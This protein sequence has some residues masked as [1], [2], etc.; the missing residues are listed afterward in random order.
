MSDVLELANRLRQLNDDDLAG[1]LRER[2]ISPNHLRD[3]FDLAET[4]LQ[5]KNAE[6]WLSSLNLDEIRAIT[7]KHNNTNSP[8][9]EIASLVF[10]A[11]A[12]QKYDFVAR[13]E[14]V[15]AELGLQNP[16]LIET[17]SQSPSALG[18]NEKSMHST[19]SSLDQ[20]AIAVFE[21]CQAL[22]EIIYDLE[23]HRVKAVGKSGVASLEIKRLAAHLG[24]PAEQVKR[25]FEI[26]HF[27]DLVGLDS[28][29]WALTL[30]SLRWIG[31]STVERWQ[32]LSSSW[33][34]MV[35]SNG[36]ALF[37]SHWADLESSTVSRFLT[38]VYPFGAKDEDSR[39]QRLIRF[40]EALGL[41]QEDRATELFAL[42]IRQEFSVAQKL[43][44]S[45]LPKTQDRI[46]VQA[47]LSIVTP[48]PLSS[49]DERA[50]RAFVET[51]QIGIASRFRLTALSL[52]TAFEG[53]VTE[54]EIRGTLAR[55]SHGQLPQPVEYLIN[56]TKKRFGRIRVL[57]D[58]PLGGTRIEC[59]EEILAS[60]ILH[61]SALRPFA[62]GAIDSRTLKTKY[63]PEV[64]YFGLR[65]IGFLAIRVDECGQ[66]IAP[67]KTA[68]L[69]QENG[70]DSIQGTIERLR[71]ADAKV[72]ESGDDESML[73]QI[74]L[75]IK[76][77]A[78]VQVSYRGQDGTEYHFT[79]E[80]IGLAN[81]RLRGKDRKADI[82]RTL[83]LSNITKLSLV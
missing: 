64:V 10:S 26:A 9:A 77:R 39:S 3:F 4:M 2:A 41:V 43:L 67:I 83:T 33:S 37:K 75:A 58:R 71:N 53:G 65:E 18:S 61:N 13:F 12:N 11:A 72:I 48:G 28:D 59:A 5:T 70:V 25:L 23:H 21:T 7:A 55:L 68:S 34:M 36:I 81:G 82:E 20:A 30:N 27:A 54:K 79:L 31:W 29:R 16:L 46:V 57:E 14:N 66:I 19:L 56:D 50:L 8:F 52:A 62:F 24:L 42:T 40:A 45:H 17:E 32:Y 73:R 51:E 80:P 44:D 78:K 22:T 1:L 15:L 49:S 74:Q 6:A 35:G 60:E 38:A 47:D 76:N 69:H 63:E